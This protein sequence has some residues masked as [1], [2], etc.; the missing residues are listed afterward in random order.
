[1]WRGGW[2]L[3][4][5]VEEWRLDSQLS[6]QTTLRKASPRARV[7]L[8]H[9]CWW[10]A[11]ERIMIT[12]EYRTGIGGALGTLLDTALLVVV[13]RRGVVSK[14]RIEGPR[15]GTTWT[16]EGRPRDVARRKNTKKEIGEKMRQYCTALVYIP[17]LSPNTVLPPDTFVEA[18][19]AVL[20]FVSCRPSCERELQLASARRVSDCLRQ[21]GIP[22]RPTADSTCMPQPAHG[23]G[24]RSNR[25]IIIIVALD[26]H[27]ATP[28]AES[29]LLLPAPSVRVRAISHGPS[30]MSVGYLSSLS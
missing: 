12:L 20:Y 17:R 1:M 8:C 4:H 3:G 18:V 6:T 7:R 25:R 30:T 11:R 14:N 5:E 26:S 29:R 15:A 10:G 24:S 19:V 9:V 28:R 21:L 23:Y 13:C 2:Q 22:T 27:C 16:R